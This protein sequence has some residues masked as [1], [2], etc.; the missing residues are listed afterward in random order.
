MKDFEVSFCAVFGT[1]L[2]VRPAVGK[3]AEVSVTY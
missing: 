1:R 3:I 2:T